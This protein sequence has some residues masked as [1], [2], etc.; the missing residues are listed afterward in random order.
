LRRLSAKTLQSYNDKLYAQATGDFLAN[1]ANEMGDDVGRLQRT[2]EDLSDTA[3]RIQE[4]EATLKMI[5]ETQGQNVTK[6]EDQVKQSEQ[7]LKERK[8]NWK[9]L[10]LR[11]LLHVIIDNDTD[12]DF[13]I[14]PEELDPMCES[15]NEL[16]KVMDGITFYEENFREEVSKTGGSIKDMMDLIKNMDSAS[17]RPPI[18]VFDP[19]KDE[20]DEDKG[21]E[22]GGETKDDL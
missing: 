19:P 7:L 18:F 16:T 1:Q 17:G 3:T 2:A 10:V 9:T 22:E 14:D 4:L 8:K 12:G 20:E 21:E 11:S 13:T 5:T 15:L 6:L